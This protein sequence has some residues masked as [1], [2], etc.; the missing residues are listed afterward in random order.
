MRTGSVRSGGAQCQRGQPAANR[1]G[2]PLVR[3]PALNYPECRPGGTPCHLCLRGDSAHVSHPSRRL[4]QTPAG[5]RHPLPR[6]GGNLPGAHLAVRRRGSLQ[7]PQRGVG[8]H[9]RLSV[10]PTASASPSNW[11]SW[12]RR[13]SGTWGGRT[14]R[15]DRASQMLPAP[16][17]GR[18]P[19]RRERLHGKPKGGSSEMDLL[20]Q[21]R[22]LTHCPGFRSPRILDSRA[23]GALG[24]GAERPCQVR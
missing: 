18:P 24:G 8:R 11:R 4:P 9:L 15:S 3:G 6:P 12:R 10:S 21:E 7:L 2:L 22:N 16:P 20:W 5:R 17:P 14:S 1:G 13:W 23:G 19:A